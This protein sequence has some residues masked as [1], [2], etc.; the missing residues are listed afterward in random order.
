MKTL[1]LIDIQHDFLPGGALAVP[2]SDAILPY[3]HELTTNFERVIATQDWHPAN[4]ESFASQHA[5]KAVFD[6]IDLHGLPQTLWPDHCIQNSAGAE[7]HDVAQVGNLEAIFRKG[8][9]KEIDSYSGFYDNGRRRTTGLHGFL[10]EK[11]I[12]ELHFAGLAADFCVYYS[13]VDALDLG[14]KVVLHE[15]GTRAI[16]EANFAELLQNLKQNPQFSVVAR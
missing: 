9:D 7:L 16:D 12:T 4:H 14:Y 8:M 5:G 10:Q 2:D 1:L 3:V 11:A 6:T 13:M 15:Q